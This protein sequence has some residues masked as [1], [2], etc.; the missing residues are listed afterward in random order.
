[1]SADEVVRLADER[2]LKAK[3][4]GRDRVVAGDADLGDGAPGDAVGGVGGPSPAAES[5]AS[6]RRT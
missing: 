5:V 3:A 6:A 1:M 4:L 2:L